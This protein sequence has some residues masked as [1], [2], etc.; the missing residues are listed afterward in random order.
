MCLA[1]FISMFTWICSH[2]FGD[3]TSIVSELFVGGYL[4]RTHVKLFVSFSCTLYVYCLSGYLFL[5][6]AGRLLLDFTSSLLLGLLSIQYDKSSF[7]LF[8]FSNICCARAL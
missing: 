5:P 4:N 6:C 8:V 1:V 3:G 7:P 2:I